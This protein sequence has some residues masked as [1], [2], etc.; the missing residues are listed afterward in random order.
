MAK[1]IALAAHDWA[2]FGDLGG[3]AALTATVDWDLDAHQPFGFQC[4]YGFGWKASRLVDFIG[5]DGGNRCNTRGAS[6]ETLVCHLG[7]E[8]H[9]ATFLSSR[10]D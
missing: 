4:I 9:Q 5:V 7:G 3:T 6:L 2:E 8:V 10:I 1:I